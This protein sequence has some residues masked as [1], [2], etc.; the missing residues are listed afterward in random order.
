MQVQH[1]TVEVQNAMIKVTKSP[2]SSA[3]STINVMYV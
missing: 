2:T 1:E 3:H